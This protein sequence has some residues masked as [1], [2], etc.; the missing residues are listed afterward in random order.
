MEKDIRLWAQTCDACQRTKIHRHIKTPIGKF[1]QPSRRFAQIHVDIVGLFPQL[2][3]YRYLFT[4]T[5]R[6]TRW[7][8]ATP[9]YDETAE[10]CAGALL[11]SWVAR[12]GLPEHITSDR[13]GVFI[14]NLWT[15]LALFLG[16]QLHHTTAYHP[17]SN[18]MIERW[19]RTLKASLTLHWIRL[20][21]PPSMGTSK[22]TH[23]T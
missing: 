20:D 18:G 22:T 12:F 14:S 4:I 2:E 21:P 6:E 1:P 17:Q 19:H 7:R 16:I 11:T 3:G 15:N 5:D 23:H 13:G 10:S 9:I 8:E